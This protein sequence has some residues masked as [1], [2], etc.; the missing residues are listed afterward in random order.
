[1]GD[2]ATAS[3]GETSLASAIGWTA[4]EGW[5]AISRDECRDRLTA[6]GQR[7]EMETVD[8]RGVPTRVWKNAPP[9]LRALAMVGR[10]YGPREFLVY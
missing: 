8:I 7:F 6:P 3:K 2:A 4:P 1:M 5:P 10:M 9:N